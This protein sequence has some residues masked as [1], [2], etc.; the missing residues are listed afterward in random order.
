MPQVY[1]NKYPKKDTDMKENLKKFKFED[2]L[3]DHSFNVRM[4]DAYSPANLATLQADINT[5]GLTEPL[6]V[7]MLK[8]PKDGKIAKV[9]RG[10][11]RSEA[12]KLIRIGDPS[13]FVE[14]DCL[15]YPASLSEQ[16]QALLMCDHGLVQKLNPFEQY[17]SVKRLRI[18]GLTQ[19]EIETRLGQK[20]GWVQERWMLA[21]LPPV[22]EQAYRA[23]FDESITGMPNITMK[24]V[25]DLN[26]VIIEAGG[27][28]TDA[29]KAAFTQ[30]WQK[31]ATGAP[32]IP[33][34]TM[35]T[36]A[37]I[38]EIL[39]LCQNDPKATAILK[40]VKGDGSIQIADHIIIS[41]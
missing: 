19:A 18:A 35:K 27:I 23:K 5:N 12:I 36:S 39:I 30:A 13:K 11:R 3:I 10:H 41:N 21:G 9:L 20:R 34:M 38:D 22:V 4:T 28:I 17:L 7:V 2:L 8:E 25:R 15:V 16:E 1:C 6:T 32:V 40:W 24:H 26:T 33:R 31:L 14:V 29:G 37:E